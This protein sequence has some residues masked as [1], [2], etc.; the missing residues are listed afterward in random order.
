M[1]ITTKFNLCFIIIWGVVYSANAQLVNHGSQILVQNGASINL[2]GDFTNVSGTVINDGTIHLT[3]NFINNDAS[4]VFTVASVGLVNLRGASQSIGGTQKT[5]FPNLTLSGSGIKKLSVNADVRQNLNIADREFELEDKSLE[6]L[7]TAVNSLSFTSGFISTDSKGYLYRNTNTTDTY[8]YPLGSKITANLVY[9]PIMIN[10]ADQSGNS[11]GLSFV[12]KDPATEGYNRNS[13][14]FDVN[15][16]N[17]L[18]FYLVDQKA[19]TSRIDYRFY[20]NQSE[21]GNFNQLVKWIDFGLWEKAAI[22]NVQPT[23]VSAMNDHVFTFSTLKPVNALPVT[24]A[25]ITPTND[26]ITIFNS[27][28][29]DGDGKNDKWEIKNIDLFPDNELTILN[30]WGSEILRVK[31]YNNAGAWDGGGL[32]NG[33]YFYLLKVNINNEAKVYKGFITLLKN[34]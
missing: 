22:S 8:T 26:P 2:T 27:F 18:Y 4:G 9:R 5:V 15:E 12:N 28:S 20:F 14:R 34:D 29:P 13:K 1:R 16:V 17:P 33:T 10:S 30:R 11:I 32:N 23:G 21:D 25:S 6:L 19:G 31:G 7:S 3:G 24:M